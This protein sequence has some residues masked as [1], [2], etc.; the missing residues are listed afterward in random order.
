M[1]HLG[2][3]T[4]KSPTLQAGAAFNICD[5]RRVI[6]T[7]AWRFKIS[8]ACK[9]EQA[10]IHKFMMLLFVP[11]LLFVTLTKTNNVTLSRLRIHKDMDIKNMNKSVSDVYY[12]ISFWTYNR[13]SGISVGDCL[14][15]FVIS[16]EHSN[17]T[18]C[19]YFNDYSD[20]YHRE[21]SNIWNSY[22]VDYKDMLF[23]FSDAQHLR[24]IL[25][26]A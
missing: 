6:Q 15:S 13:H 7:T 23:K 21:V 17:F 5:F 4:T 8:G 26:M 20:L 10:L 3:I 24:I 22:Q 11:H 16:Y 18:N 25:L 1:S 2:L 14:H 9:R 12:M 19:Y